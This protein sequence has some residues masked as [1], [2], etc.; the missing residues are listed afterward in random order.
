MMG[1]FQVFVEA[2]DLGREDLSL[3]SNYFINCV[4]ASDYF[5]ICVFFNCDSLVIK[6]PEKWVVIFRAIAGMVVKTVCV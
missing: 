1:L 6:K 2:C 4:A 5:I 3:Q